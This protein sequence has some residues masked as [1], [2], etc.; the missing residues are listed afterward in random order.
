MV[1]NQP[2]RHCR[3][4]A[5]GTADRLLTPS[6][7]SGSR[8][9][10][11]RGLASA[12]TVRR[13]GNGT[14][15]GRRTAV[16]AAHR[17]VRTD[18]VMHATVATTTAPTSTVLSPAATRPLLRLPIAPLVVTSGGLAAPLGVSDDH[19][20]DLLADAAWLHGDLPCPVAIGPGSHLGP[21]HGGALNSP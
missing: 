3:D 20:R 18:V 12:T 6:R 4:T 21:G 5:G 2:T 19:L 7:R 11:A 15:R 17:R 1:A 16:I 14:A 10:H 9:G 8:R 13:G